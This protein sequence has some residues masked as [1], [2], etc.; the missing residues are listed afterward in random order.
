[1]SHDDEEEKTLKNRW[2]NQG[3][4]LKGFEEIYENP[5]T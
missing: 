1:M 2:K 5:N 3:I 4:K